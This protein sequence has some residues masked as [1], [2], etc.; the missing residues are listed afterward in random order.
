[1]RCLLGHRYRLIGTVPYMDTSWG[2]RWPTTVL[3]RQCRWCGKVND[4]QLVTGTWTV[5]ELVYAPSGGGIP[6][7]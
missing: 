4:R 1:M 5:E 7:S 6:G 2:A 3:I